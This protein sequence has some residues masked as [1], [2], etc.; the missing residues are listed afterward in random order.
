MPA[1]AS[2]SARRA[3][4]SERT[5]DSRLSSVGVSNEEMSAALKERPQIGGIS[6]TID[7]FGTVTLIDLQRPATPRISSADELRS[8]CQGLFDRIDSDGNDYLSAEE[9]GAAMQSRQYIGLDAQAVAALYSQRAALAGLSNDDWGRDSQVS[10]A[11]LAA[12]ASGNNSDAI[13]DAL[14]SATRTHTSQENRLASG[15]FATPDNP[16]LS[17]HP[18]AI[19]QGRIGDCYFLA[20]LAALA[21]TNPQAIEDMIRDN[22]NGTYTVTFPGDR[23]NPVTVNAPTEAEAGLFNGGHKY[24]VWANVLEN[25]YGRYWQEHGGLITSAWRGAMRQFDGYAPS[26]GAD[27]GGRSENATRLLTGND[28]QTYRTAW[29]SAQEL[30]DLLNTALNGEH[31]RS[32]TA[33]INNN[34]FS[35]TSQDGFS[36]AHAYSILAYVPTADGSV[37]QVIVRNPW[38]QGENS[39]NGTITVSVEEFQR[40]FS[41]FALEQPAV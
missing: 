12:I 40:N 32:V 13:R 20:S 3:D 27:G 1:E 30:G 15:L 41:D 31:P 10:R 6:S 8:V 33:A 36:D 35:S 21:Q 4:V 39:R 17:I 29:R 16:R 37:G 14:Y 9:L 24:G 23:D 11:D 28:T 22:G 18:E 38:G 2:V 19:Q 7:E 5:R 26:E 25:A 34:P